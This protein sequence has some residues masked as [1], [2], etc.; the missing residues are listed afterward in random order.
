M[1]NY[2]RAQEPALQRHT[3]RMRLSCSGVKERGNAMP[4]PRCSNFSTRRL[5]LK[6]P[7]PLPSSSPFGLCDCSSIYKITCSYISFWLIVWILKLHP[8]GVSPPTADMTA[9]AAQRHG[10]V[11]MPENALKRCVCCL[12]IILFFKLWIVPFLRL[13]I[14]LA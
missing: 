10:A 11:W 1:L 13:A 6:E 4:S 5:L 14:R 2:A 12:Y 3:R 8:P 9:S 7:L